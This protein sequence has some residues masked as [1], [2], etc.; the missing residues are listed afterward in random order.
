MIEIEDGWTS[1]PNFYLQALMPYLTDPEYKCLMYIARHTYG[2]HKEEDQISLSQFKEGFTNQEGNKYDYGT[3]LCLSAIEKALLEL[4]Y[5]KLIIKVESG[6]SYKIPTKWK[7]QQDLSAVDYDYLNYK[8]DLKKK[9]NRNRTKKARK[10]RELDL[11]SE[12]I[13][14]KNDIPEDCTI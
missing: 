5:A 9:T 8:Y 14:L 6:K 10:T 13:F 3:G 12:N 4:Q 7:L 11:H 1:I 2:W